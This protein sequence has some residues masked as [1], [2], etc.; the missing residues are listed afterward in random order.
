MALTVG[1]ALVGATVRL[2]AA[3][4]IV[5]NASSEKA[6]KPGCCA[7]KACCETSSKHT[8]PPAQPLAKSSIDQQNVTAISAIAAVTLVMP[9]ATESHVFSSTE[10]RAHS[11][12]PLALICIRLI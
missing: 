7:N 6:C 10:C 5:T 11:P 3:T 12:R 9:A 8:G 4:C 1:L 2:P